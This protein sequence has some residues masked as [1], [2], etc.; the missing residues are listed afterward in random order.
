MP[1]TGTGRPMGHEFLGV[2]EATGTHVTS[3]KPGDLVVT[4]F[5]PRR[6]PTL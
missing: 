4:Q 3:V 5:S 6:A 2:V 1:A